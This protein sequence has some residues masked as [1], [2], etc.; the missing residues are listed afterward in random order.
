MTNVKLLQL[1]DEPQEQP[2][3]FILKGDPRTYADLA[4]PQGLKEIASYAQAIGPWKRMILPEKADKTLD[5]PTRL[6]QD[7][8]AAGLWVH[9]YTFRNE[10]RYLSADY[11][12]DPMAE[13]LQF[14]KLGVDAVFTDFP[15]TAVLARRRF[16]ELIKGE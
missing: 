1:L 13:Y 9:P 16:Y 8:H 7:A 6:V 2:Y 3:D 15:D 12:N 14:F 11:Q 4:K 10:E 5:Q